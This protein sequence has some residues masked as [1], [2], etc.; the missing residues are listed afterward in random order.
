[1]KKMIIG[2]SAKDCMAPWLTSLSLAVV[3]F[4]CLS[5]PAFGGSVKKIEIAD[6]G[7]Y[8]TRVNPDTK[9]TGI[10]I[11]ETV[12]LVKKTDIIPG[13]VGTVFG[14]RF[15][16]QGE[17]KGEEVVVMHKFFP[18]EKGRLLVEEIQQRGL[19]GNK[20]YRAFRFDTA[21]EIVPGTWRFEV[22]HEGKKMAEKSFTVTKAK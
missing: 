21:N 22:W 15:V 6:Y 20:L 18:P 19:M 10:K 11:A 1:M 8:E 4:A 2:L 14:F 13:K 16:V 17:P 7:I 9:A 5:V 12:K 3:L